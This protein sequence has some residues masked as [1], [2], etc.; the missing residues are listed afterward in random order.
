MGTDTNAPY[1]LDLNVIKICAILVTLP[2][3]EEKSNA[4]KW[5]SGNTFRKILSNPI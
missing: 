2:P 5:I 1:L 4:V 3:G